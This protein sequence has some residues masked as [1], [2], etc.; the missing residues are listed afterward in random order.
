MSDNNAC[1]VSL[2]PVAV[3]SHKSPADK[4]FMSLSNEEDYS[5]LYVSW[6]G[7]RSARDFP[8]VTFHFTTVFLY[9]PAPIYEA[10]VW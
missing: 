4:I 3:W 1:P 8:P 6:D 10:P 5:A 2:L 7:C 9:S